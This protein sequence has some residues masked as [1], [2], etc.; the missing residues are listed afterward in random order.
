MSTKKSKDTTTKDNKVSPV[1]NPEMIS[2]VVGLRMVGRSMNKIGKLLG[3][4]RDTV[5]RILN[6]SEA[7]ELVSSLRNSV[8]LMGPKATEVLAEDL[9]YKGGEYQMR[10]LRNKTALRVLQGSD[11]LPKDGGA[12]IQIQHNTIYSDEVLKLLSTAINEDMIDVDLGLGGDD[13]A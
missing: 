4:H 1:N 11:V 10:Q 7:Q 2:S 12:T 9:T 3:I 8:L 13:E 5:R 6:T